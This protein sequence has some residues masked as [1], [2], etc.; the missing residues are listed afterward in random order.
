MEKKHQDI[1]HF[2]NHVKLDSEVEKSMEG[3]RMDILEQVHRRIDREARSRRMKERWMVAA[4]F[5]LLLV[6][7]GWL[8][9]QTGFLRPQ[10]IEE[11]SV[12]PGNQ[13]TVTLPDGTVVMLNGGTRLTYDTKA[14]GRKLRE[15]ALDG[16]AFFEVAKNREVPF[17]VNNGEAQVK[18]LGTSFNV[19]GYSADAAIRVTLKSGKVSMRIAGTPDDCV[20]V[21]GQQVV[22]MKPE[23]RLIRRQVKVDEVTAWRKGEMFFDDLSLEEIASRLE[24]RFGVPVVIRSEALKQSRYNGA[25]TP[26]DNLERILSFLSLMDA[27][28]HYEKKEGTIWIY[29]DEK[30]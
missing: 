23:H 5:A 9:L 26:E 27:R 19:E 8:A 3:M 11:F 18:V 22:Y 20:L 16:E 4:S 10:H 21:P 30:P 28:L 1:P 7:S 15:V 24:R 25:F 14:F 29:S 6:L 17:I 12:L 2:L 13:A